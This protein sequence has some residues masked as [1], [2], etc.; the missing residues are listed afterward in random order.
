MDQAAQDTH[1]GT[2]SALNDFYNHYIVT[3]LHGSFQVFQSFT[4]GE[5]TISLL[6][7]SI[8]LLMVFKWVYEVTR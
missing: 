1:D 4:Y 6:L 3:T 8:F 5:M 7:F 2:L